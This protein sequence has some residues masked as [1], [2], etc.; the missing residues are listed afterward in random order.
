MRDYDQQN[1]EA[2]REET[3]DVKK[4]KGL[5]SGRIGVPDGPGQDLY[6]RH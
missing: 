5:F 6:F 2:I 1:T 4:R 3:E